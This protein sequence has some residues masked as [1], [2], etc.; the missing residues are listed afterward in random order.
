V[1]SIGALLVAHSF[2]TQLQQASWNRSLTELS[3]PLKPGLG[4]PE[5]SAKLS[6]LQSRV[7]ISISIE[8]HGSGQSYGLL[9]L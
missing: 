9:G 1:L 3:Y 7:P 4:S 5:V 2:A 6:Q 8:G